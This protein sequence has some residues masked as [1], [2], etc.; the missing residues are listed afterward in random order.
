M[1]NIDLFNV[2]FRRTVSYTVCSI[3][4]RIVKHLYKLYNGH[5]QPIRLTYRSVV[6]DWLLLR[7]LTFILYHTGW[8]EVEAARE[9][10]AVGL[11]LE[12]GTGTVSRSNDCPSPSPENSHE[13]HELIRLKLYNQIKNV[14]LRTAFVEVASLK[15]LRSSLLSAPSFWYMIFLLF[16]QWLSIFYC[17]RSIKILTMGLATR[18]RFQTIV[19]WLLSSVLCHSLRDG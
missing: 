12:Y 6:N 7:T 18:F 9:E 1:L 4:V 16:K 14:F 2:T 8:V 3:G 5:Y 17:S 19:I 11:M 10:C 15:S 13:L